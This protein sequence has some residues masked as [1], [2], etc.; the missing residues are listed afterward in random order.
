MQTLPQR[1]KTTDTMFTNE[2][3]GWCTRGSAIS[4]VHGNSGD[5]K[6][7]NANTSRPGGTRGVPS[8]AHFPDDVTGAGYAALTCAI[9]LA[10]VGRT[11]FLVENFRT[12]SQS[13]TWK[14]LLAFFQRPASSMLSDLEYSW[15]MAVLC[16][17]YCE[18]PTERTAE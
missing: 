7:P 1:C 17:T 3:V 11:H 12:R 16:T 18:I 5:T 10:T 6:L 14:P 4:E 9:K 2:S 8:V 15:H 13:R